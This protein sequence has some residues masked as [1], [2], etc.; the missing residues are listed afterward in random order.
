MGVVG[1]TY[2]ELAPAMPK[3]GGGLNFLLRGMGPRWSFVGSWAGAADRPTGRRRRHPRDPLV[4]DD[5][6]DDV[7]RHARQ[8]PRRAQVTHMQLGTM[9]TGDILRSKGEE[10]RCPVACK[11]PTIR[12]MTGSTS[13]AAPPKWPRRWPRPLLSHQPLHGRPSAQPSPRSSARWDPKRQTSRQSTRVNFLECG[14][15]LVRRW[16]GQLN[17]Q[18][19]C[20][21]ARQ[22]ASFTPIQR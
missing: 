8:P 19:P 22:G 21:W 14:G 4:R 9:L 15:V 13:A 18:C 7:V 12:A 20:C 3:A 11:R 6:P 10:D 2:A 1:L 5:H 16:R 17:T